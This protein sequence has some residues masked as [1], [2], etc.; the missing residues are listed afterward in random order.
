MTQRSDEEKKLLNE[1]LPNVAAQMRGPLSVL[2]ASL[3]KMIQTD[4]PGTALLNQSYYQ[5]LR[6][7]GNLSMAELL[8]GEHYLRKRENGDIVVFCRE[9]AEQVGLLAEEQ[10]VTV[11]FFLCGAVLCDCL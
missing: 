11:Q 6:L 2:H 3:Q 4:M 10:G 8:D 7:A 9:L 5:L 1:V